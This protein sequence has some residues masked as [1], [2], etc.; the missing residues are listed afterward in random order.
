MRD[1][2]WRR[3]QC[4]ISTL[5][6]GSKDNRDFLIFNYWAYGRTSK[7]FISESLSFMRP[8]SNSI[9]L[10]VRSP[11]SFRSV[12]AKPGGASV[13]PERTAQTDAHP[14]RLTSVY[15]L[16]PSPPPLPPPP[17]S[18]CRH[19]ATPAIAPQK[20][21]MLFSAS[22]HVPSVILHKIPLNSVA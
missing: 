1:Q 4:G 12:S 13:Q 6:L 9:S 20:Q 7:Q 5:E 17:P 16:P 11:N 19:S 8:V 3:Q 10:R 22:V 14:V 2:N 15:N 21:R 18:R